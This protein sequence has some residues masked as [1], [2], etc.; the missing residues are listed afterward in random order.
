M[1]NIDFTTLLPT[2]TSWLVFIAALLV[3]C[4]NLLYLTKNFTRRQNMHFSFA[5]LALYMAALYFMAIVAPTTWLIRS[6]I[7]T[8]VGILILFWMVAKITYMDERDT[9]RDVPR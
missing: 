5:L 2:A 1:I 8:K 6:G 3:A 9:R 7:A 4:Q